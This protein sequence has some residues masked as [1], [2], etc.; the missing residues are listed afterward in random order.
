MSTAVAQPRAAGQ[1]SDGKRPF[2]LGFHTPISFPAGSLPH[3]RPDAARPHAADPPATARRWAKSRSRPQCSWPNSAPARSAGPICVG[4]PGR[5]IEPGFG[6]AESPGPGPRASI[7]Q[8]ARGD[9]PEGWRS[10]H[11]MR[12]EFANPPMLAPPSTPC[13][14]PAPAPPPGRGRPAPPAQPPPLSRRSRCR[15]RPA[16]PARPAASAPPPGRARPPGR[17]RAAA[18]PRPRRRPA[19]PAQ[20]PLAL[21]PAAPPPPALLASSVASSVPSGEP[22]PVQASQPGPAL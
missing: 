7:G 12:D 5:T 13:P 3:P 19:A 21:P 15:R 22:R 6:P 16:A 11:C 4:P 18:R 14:C 2:K 10:R 17:V 9:R 8:R 1:P 20:P